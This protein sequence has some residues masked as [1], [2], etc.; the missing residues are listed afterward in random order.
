[1]NKYMKTARLS[2]L[3]KTN[4]GVVYL[5]PDV[6]I[7]IF[8]LIPLLYLWRTVM[9]SGSQVGMSLEQMLSYTS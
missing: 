2:A 3:E 1:M 4:G 9:S 6:L 8:T 5:L 7:K